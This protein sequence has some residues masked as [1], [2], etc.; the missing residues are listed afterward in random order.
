MDITTQ[1][2]C[3]VYV[4]DAIMVQTLDRQEDLVL[5]GHNVL[6]DHVGGKCYI[7]IQAD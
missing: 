4:A 2:E 1:I 3:V 6:V 5:H 7:T